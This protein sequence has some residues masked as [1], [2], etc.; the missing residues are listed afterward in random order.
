[1]SICLCDLLRFAQGG[2]RI[3]LLQCTY[4]ICNVLCCMQA[5]SHER[6][7][8]TPADSEGL[9]NLLLL[10]DSS[11]QC[12]SSDSEEGAQ[13]Y[14]NTS[15]SSNNSAD[16]DVEPETSP[17]HTQPAVEGGTDTSSSSCF[18]GEGL[19]HQGSFCTAS[20]TAAKRVW[21]LNA[22]RYHDASLHL[23]LCLQSSSSVC[24]EFHRAC[25]V[26]GCM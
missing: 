13:S 4:C 26:K 17:V 2:P 5:T 23:I 9:L 8:C 15:S 25:Y 21:F 11:P 1:M 24:F 12:S 10:A 18:S 6:P 7:V 16:S 3:R 14:D 20:V 19:E 22:G